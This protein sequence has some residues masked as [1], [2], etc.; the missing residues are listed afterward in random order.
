M[1]KQEEIRE[2]INDI[3]AEWGVY[4]SEATDD[5]LNYLHSQGAVLEVKGEL[6]R[7]PHAPE[8]IK[9]VV[10][11]NLIDTRDRSIYKIAQQDMLNDGYVKTESIKER[12]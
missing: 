5:I 4:R 2:G 12:K 6:P 7:N 1:D 9:A 10:G 3:F 8:E 11:C